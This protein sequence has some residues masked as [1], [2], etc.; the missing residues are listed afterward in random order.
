M[1]APK[2]PGAPRSSSRG[3]AR[4]P[5]QAGQ[6]SAPRGTTR[7]PRGPRAQAGDTRP[8]D[9]AFTPK[10]Q[11]PNRPQP[12]AASRPAARPAPRRAAG[13]AATANPVVARASSPRSRTR[14]GGPSGPG[15]AA[16]SPKPRIEPA[17]ARGSFIG[18]L[19][20]RS[21]VLAVVVVL[22]LAVLL[23]S[24]RVYFGQQEDLRALRA[25][26]AQAE[27]DVT[28]LQADVGRW[29]DPAYVVAQAR[30]R[31]AYVFPGETPYRVVD[32][33]LV[34]STAAPVAGAIEEPTVPD[35]EPWYSNL[36]NSI[37]DAGTAPAPGPNPSPS[38]QP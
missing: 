31:L 21:A 36:W 22:A 27:A 15:R 1:S 32:P 14:P 19:S 28:E 12:K 4:A 3:D 25:D 35:R 11:S 9:A 38:P 13:P 2:R 6:P 20:W 5:S 30:E 34:D 16:A 24:L 33:E 7:R 26:A 10:E 37:E 18:T 29:N 17:K 8:P 23:P